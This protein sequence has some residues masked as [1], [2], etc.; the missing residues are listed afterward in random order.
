MNNIPTEVVL[1]K[2]ENC[3]SFGQK[4]LFKVVFCPGQISVTIKDRDTGIFCS[5][6]KNIS[7]VQ[8]QGQVPLHSGSSEC[9]RVFKLN[10]RS[11]SIHLMDLFCI[12]KGLLKTHE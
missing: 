4:P 6:S 2:I 11:M 8:R 3:W 9:G 12:D 1:Q 10:V 5:V 7:I